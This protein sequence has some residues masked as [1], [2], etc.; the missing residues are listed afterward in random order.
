MHGLAA[1]ERLNSS[2]AMAKLIHFSVSGVSTFS[3]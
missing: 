3:A 1:W 2:V